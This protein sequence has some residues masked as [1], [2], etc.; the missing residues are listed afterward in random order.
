[1]PDRT[2]TTILELSTALRSRKLSP[3]E[4]TRSC[5]QRIETLN[6]TLNAFITVT[7]ELALRQAPTAKKELLRGNWRG[8]PPGIPIGLKD[9]IDTA[10]IPTTA[11]S[12]QYKHRI[13]TQTA[14]VV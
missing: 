1:M 12:E 7:A 3:V 11:G 5:L 8:P 4:L 14:D 10:E 2:Q 6:P 9:L 13:P